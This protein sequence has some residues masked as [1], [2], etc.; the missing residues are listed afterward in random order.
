MRSRIE[1]IGLGLRSRY[2]TIVSGEYLLL[3]PDT[4]PCLN[5]HA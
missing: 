4:F 3:P 1:L 2:S 5:I